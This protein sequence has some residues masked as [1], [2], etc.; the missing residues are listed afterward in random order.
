MRLLLLMTF[1]GVLAM[2]FSGEEALAGCSGNACGDLFIKKRDGCI[3]L[4]NRNPRRQ[5]RV[6]GPNW[7]PAYVFY[8]Y[9]NSEE[10]VKTMY[11]N[12]LNDW[13]EQWNA[14]YKD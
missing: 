8:V 7:I 13:H 5:I 3:I 4:E 1:L 10:K 9:P 12:C 6:D 14:V 2:M 11:A